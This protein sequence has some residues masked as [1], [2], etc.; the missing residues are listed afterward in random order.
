V[1]AALK[2]EFTLAK[3]QLLAAA[4]TKDVAAV[5]RL[6]HQLHTALATLE[7]TTLSGSLNAVAEGDWD[8]VK[9]CHAAMEA[10]CRRL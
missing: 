3:E 10:V 8:Q 4:A 5:K 9:S 6:R 2:E 1:Q 7:L